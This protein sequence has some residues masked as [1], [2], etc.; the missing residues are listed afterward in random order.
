MGG[1]VKKLKLK[2]ISII[3]KLLLRSE[4][5][6][7]N[8]LYYKLAKKHFN[9]HFGTNLIDEV[10]NATENAEK[11]AARHARLVVKVLYSDSTPESKRRLRAAAR[12]SFTKNLLLETEL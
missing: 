11:A 6:L 12:G 9:I 8:K 4:S 1:N 7:A 2:V 5:E 10:G 3:Q